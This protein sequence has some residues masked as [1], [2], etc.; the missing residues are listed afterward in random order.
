MSTGIV[1]SSAGVLLTMLGGLLVL[2]AAFLT[3]SMWSRQ[4]VAWLR[5]LWPLRSRESAGVTIAVIGTIVSCFALGW[6]FAPPLALAVLAIGALQI[7]GARL[8]EVHQLAMDAGSLATEL[9]TFLD[10]RFAEKM[11][12]ITRINDAEYDQDTV[13]HYIE[14]FEWRVRRVAREFSRHKACSADV[15]FRHVDEGCKSEH[16]IFQ[17]TAGLERLAKQLP[18]D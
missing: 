16:D 11:R 10:D 9:R 18:E 15:F 6:W 13:G 1:G 2:I 3:R 5:P 7:R 12:L 8:R 4:I 17:I 14:R